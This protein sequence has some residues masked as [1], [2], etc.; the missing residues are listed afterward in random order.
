VTTIIACRTLGKMVADTRI[1]HGEQKFRSRRK[2]QRVGPF[3]VGV[4]GDYARA[5]EYAKAFAKVAKKL[6]GRMAPKLPAAEGEGD[7]EMVVMSAHG[8][9]YYGEDGTPIEIEEEEYYTTGSGGS[10]ASSSLLTQAFLI[11]AGALPGYDLALAMRVACEYDNDSDL[12]MV[13]LSLAGDA[14]VPGARRRAARAQG[15]GG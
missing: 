5:L 7:L 9:W 14:Q 10:W 12:P 4:S 2:I 1:T 11:R 6:D 13:E 8:L 3:L 15:V